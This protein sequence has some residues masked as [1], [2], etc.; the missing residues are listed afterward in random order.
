MQ[1]RFSR[2][3]GLTHRVTT[4]CFIVLRQTNIGSL[5]NPATAA[6]SRVGY[7]SLSHERC[8]WIR[9]N[10]YVIQ[11]GP[12]TV[13]FQFKISLLKQP[14]GAK[15]TIFATLWQTSAEQ[16]FGSSLVHALKF[17]FWIKLGS[18]ELQYSKIVVLDISVNVI[19]AITVTEIDC[20]FSL[21]QHVAP[22]LRKNRNRPQSNLTAGIC[23]TLKNQANQQ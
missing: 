13:H 5:W 23:R 19:F 3:P 6:D 7:G 1:S 22:V 21:V 17:L 2:S 12:K 16:R 9:S 18:I 20:S 10:I 15:T 4:W 14:H 8:L 11:G